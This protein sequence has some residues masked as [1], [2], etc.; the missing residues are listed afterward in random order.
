MN[1]EAKVHSDGAVKKAP[2]STKDEEEGARTSG[3]HDAAAVGGVERRRESDA[4]HSYF[5]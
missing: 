5:Q 2:M 4:L 1:D 3:D